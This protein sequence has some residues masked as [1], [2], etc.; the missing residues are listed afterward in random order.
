[1][2]ARRPRH[3]AEL[4]VDDRH[5]RALELQPRVLRRRD[6][7]VLE[8]RERDRDLALERVGHADHRALG[9]RRVAGD[10][11][12]DLAR[13]EPVAGDVDHVVGPPEDEV[14]A[15]VVADAPVEGRVDEPVRDRVEVGVDE[16]L[17]VAPHRLH[18]ARRQRR[19]DRD[20]ALLVGADLGAGALVEQSDVVAVHRHARAADPGRRLLDAVRDGQD[21]P[22]GLGL[23]V[24]V[25]D[26]PA[27]RVGDPLRGRLVERLAGEEQRAQA[28]QVVLRQPT[29]ILLL[30][31]PDRGGRGEHH[32]RL[33]ALHELPEDPR[34][35]AQRRALV[36]DRRHPADQR[37]V[38]DVRV[39]DHPADVAGAEVGLAGV[40]AEDVLHGRRERDRVAA[41]VAL[42]ALGPA[43][44]ARGVQDVA[45]LVRLEPGDRHLGVEVLRAQRRVVLVAPRDR[46][47]RCELAV[48]HQHLAGLV[49]RQPDR[50]VQERLVGHHLA[51]ARAAVGADDQR[52]RGVL[53]P[54]READRR[55]A[56]EDHRMDRPDPR[57]GE[58]REHRLR[59]H[60]HVDEHPIAAAHA[61]R[62]HRRGHPLD[63][64][65]QLREGVGARLVGL[66]RDVDQR[67]P[68]G[69]GRQPA[70]D[71]V[72]AQVGRAADEPPRERRARVVEHA[73]ERRVPVDAAGL[74]GPER[75]SVVDRPAVDAAVVH[76]VSLAPRGR[77]LRARQCGTGRLRTAYAPLADR[78]R[79]KP[80][81]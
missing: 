69:L 49:R 5:H 80:R 52:R 18:A 78:S 7:R 77:V 2:H 8:H 34:V 32:R 81:G 13:A 58:H 11:L 3:R 21:R 33:V 72:V 36:Q 39:P 46:L 37:P 54:A 50:L 55:E 42:H 48:D 9:D 24:V 26:R 28:R 61:E 66:G 17:V 19:H 60:R 1:M 53:D 30:Q 10:R 27:D 40:A 73:L 70:V 75:V 41:D 4:L 15:V 68:V 25:H 63:L 74:L 67:G 29:R 79:T 23:P 14:V 59:D 45:G 65:V 20:D 64:A 47:E 22:A 57:A 35:G 6:R 56:A 16:A 71:R 38:D 44:R 12:L 76:D 51:A 43:R 31:H 62:R